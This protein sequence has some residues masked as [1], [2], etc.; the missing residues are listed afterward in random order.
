MHVS[1]AACGLDSLL[2]T[3]EMLCHSYR[4]VSSALDAQI[5]FGV[6]QAT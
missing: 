1:L 3:G 4:N 6:R 5:G 2:I